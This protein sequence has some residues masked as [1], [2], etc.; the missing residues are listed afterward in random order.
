MRHPVIFR[1]V[2]DAETGASR[3]IVGLPGATAVFE[4][5]RTTAAAAGAL[6]SLATQRGRRSRDL[7][8]LA[9]PGV[10]SP[11]HRVYEKLKR[12]ANDIAAVSPQLGT[13]L[14]RFR[15]ETEGDRVKCWLPDSTNA[16][17]I[18]EKHDASATHLCDSAPAI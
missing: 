12:V 4:P 15:C 14:A 6:H 17:L 9:P 18:V 1:R 5:S 11:R 13:A 10:Q 2:D 3:Y 8:G 16:F 7:S